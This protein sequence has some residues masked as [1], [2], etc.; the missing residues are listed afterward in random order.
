MLFFCVHVLRKSNF[1][2]NFYITYIYHLHYITLH[3][4]HYIISYLEN[5]INTNKNFDPHTLSLKVLFEF[6]RL[7]YIHLI[8]CFK[9]FSE[10]SSSKF[11]RSF[12]EK[13]VGIIMC[14]LYFAYTGCPSNGSTTGN[15]GILCEDAN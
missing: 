14:H 6:D 1:M 5:E 7:N 11:E 12:L 3:Y 10:L 13:H 15:G 8:R 2:L 9:I 4:L